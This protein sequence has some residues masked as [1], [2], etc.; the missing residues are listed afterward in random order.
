MRFPCRCGS[1]ECYCSLDVALALTEML[2][3][4]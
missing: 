1:V 4:W 3:V 2:E